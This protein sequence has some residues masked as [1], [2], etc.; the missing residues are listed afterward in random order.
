[1]PWNHGDVARHSNPNHRKARP[2]MELNLLM[3]TMTAKFI[4]RAATVLLTCAGIS[5]GAVA[6]ALCTESDGTVFRAAHDPGYVLSDFRCELQREPQ[7]VDEPAANEGVVIPSGESPSSSTAG[8][9]GGRAGGRGAAQGKQMARNR[10][11]HYAS[12]INASARTWGHD[13]ALLH[14]IVSVESDYSPE[15]VSSKGAVGLMQVTPATAQRYGLLNPRSELMNPRSNVELGARHL[16]SLKR[17]FDGDLRLALAGYN[18]G[19]QAVINNGRRIPPFPE[20]RAY[21]RDVIDRY[22]TLKQCRDVVE[23]VR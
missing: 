5:S 23:C 3:S 8:W 17:A 18:A 15:A 7:P 13:P 12:V 20:T 9:S 4:T 21:V 11:E 19:E 10:A 14:A 6:A 2:F 1:M 16:A 22:L